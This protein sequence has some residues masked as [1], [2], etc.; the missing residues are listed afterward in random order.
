MG[1]QVVSETDNKLASFD[2]VISVVSFCLFPAADPQQLELD[3]LAPC[4]FF[5]LF[6]LRSNK[7]TNTAQMV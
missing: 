4:N 5:F 1:E 3:S 6:I 2:V 7:E